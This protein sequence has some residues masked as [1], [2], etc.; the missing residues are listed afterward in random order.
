MT[1]RPTH[2][3]LMSTALTRRA[4][5]RRSLVSGGS[6]AALGSSGLLTACGG[7]ESAQAS[8]AGGT[9]L[10]FQLGWLKGVQFGGHFAAIEQGYFE[11]A[12]IAPTFD[13]GGPNI[14]QISVVSSGQ[15]LLGD[16]G[17]DELVVA[18]ASGIPVR[19]IA[20]G[21]QKSPYS[22]MS[23]ASAPIQSL[24]DMEGKSIAVSDGSRPQIESLLQ[25]AG[26]DP[27]SVQFVPKNPDPSVLADGVVDG[28]TGFSTNE[29]AT[30]RERGVDIVTVFFSD[31]GAPT[32]ANVLFTTDDALESNRDLIVEFLRAD[33]RGWQWAIDN[34]DELAEVVVEK[35]AAEG[36]ELGPQTAEAQAQVELI[37]ADDAS[38][39]GL[40][41]IAGD[42]F[43]TNIAAALEAG[44]IDEE[45]AAADVFTQ[46]VI[47]EVHAA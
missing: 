41:W 5:L 15:A 16:S 43:E 12:G 37:D 6:L 3:P 2:P 28:Y 9:A 33:V 23:L 11:E 40:F 25:A 47:A 4:F 46:D 24:E 17:S 26:V 35:Y 14:D 7:G 10:T 44:L 21:F 20:A 45:I 8:G 36:L 31:L 30:L 13:S 38:E 18:R 19:A 39:N 27:A 34:P 29:G 42:T 1:R 22:V 32:Y